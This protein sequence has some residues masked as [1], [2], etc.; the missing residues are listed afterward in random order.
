MCEGAF[1]LRAS[2]W[3]LVVMVWFLSFSRFGHD[4]R[5]LTPRQKAAGQLGEAQA[6]SE[7]R[8]VREAE[9]VLQLDGPTQR[10]NTWLQG[11][12]LS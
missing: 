7:T 4:H 5:G 1:E 2:S 3:F 6:S 12:P 10:L 11:R 9:T 8:R